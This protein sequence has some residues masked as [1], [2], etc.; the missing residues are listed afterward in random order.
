MNLIRD[1]MEYG[2]LRLWN[3]ND[4]VYVELLL[5]IPIDGTDGMD[6]LIAS[7]DTLESAIEIMARELN[8]LREPKPSLSDGSS[9]NTDTPETRSA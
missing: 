2:E 7:S 4:A 3:C 8:R 1:L 9:R 5:E 6:A